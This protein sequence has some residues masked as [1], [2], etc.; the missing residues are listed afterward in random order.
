MRFLKLIP[1]FFLIVMINSCGEEESADSWFA[2]EEIAPVGDIY[3][4]KDSLRESDNAIYLHMSGDQETGSLLKKYEFVQVLDNGE[5]DSKMTTV[6][7]FSELGFT[8]PRILD[9]AVSTCMKRPYAI[10][11]DGTEG[12]YFVDFTNKTLSAVGKYYNYATLWV[13][14]CNGYVASHAFMAGGGVLTDETGSKNISNIT[15]GGFFVYNSTSGNYEIVDDAFDNL[16]NFSDVFEN[17]TDIRVIPS[18][19]DEVTKFISA[20]VFVNADSKLKILQ[21]TDSQGGFIDDTTRFS[22][23]FSGLNVNV[24][25]FDYKGTDLTSSTAHFCAVGEDSKS[26]GYKIYMWNPSTTY[27]DVP[28][29]ETDYPG[30]CSVTN[31]SDGDGFSTYTYPWSSYNSAKSELSLVWRQFRTSDIKTMLIDKAKSSNWV[32]ATRFNYISKS[33][34]SFGRIMIFYDDNEFL[35]LAV[36]KK[37]SKCTVR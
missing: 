32:F 30:R 20:V 2:F 11:S 16:G 18:R 6:A 26:D 34:D 37:R 33:G 36:C 3:Y 35:K 28:S 13:D 10:V 24:K 4:A 9:L 27:S 21:W 31:Y 12:T 19:G 5:V 29:T 17:A 22:T 23:S 8:D 15:D 14:D 7:T 1:I 25:T